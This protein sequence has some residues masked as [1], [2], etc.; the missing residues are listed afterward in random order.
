[1]SNNEDNTGL[2]KVILFEGIVITCVFV[3]SMNY[4][5][6]GGILALIIV[7]I[8]LAIAWLSIYVLVGLVQSLYRRHKEDKYWKKQQELKDK[9][10]FDEMIRRLSNSCENN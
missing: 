4:G 10:Q 8:V 3:M 7:P 6:L 9:E 1:M 5:I 2:L